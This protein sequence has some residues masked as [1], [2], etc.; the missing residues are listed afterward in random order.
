[1]N[2]NIIFKIAWRLSAP[3]Q[4]AGR[5]FPVV[6]PTA[7]HFEDEP[8]NVARINERVSQSA[9]E[10]RA[11]TV[12]FVKMIEFGGILLQKNHSRRKIRSSSERE[13]PA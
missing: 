1:M 13:I 12:G 8:R 10:N 5:A 6:C 2:M 7:A 4:S 11:M 9:R 3:C